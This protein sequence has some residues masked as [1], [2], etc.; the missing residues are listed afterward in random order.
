MNN[1]LRYTDPSGYTWW[2]H[3]TNWVGDNWKPIVAVAA[4]TAFCIATGG[5]G[6]ALIGAGCIWNW[7]SCCPSNKR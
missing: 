5:F 2:S 3:F 4:A 1:P 7:K 6:A